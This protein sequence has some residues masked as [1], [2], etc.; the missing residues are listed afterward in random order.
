MQHIAHSDWMF[1]H[2]HHVN[3]SADPTISAESSQATQPQT[4]TDSVSPALKTYW[5]HAGD[6]TNGSSSSTQGSTSSDPSSSSGTR[7]APALTVANTALTVD[8]GG[9]TSLPI[10][11]SPANGHT[12]VTIAGLTN[13]ETVTDSL[14]GKTFTPD[15]NGSVTLSA[16]EVNSGLSLASGYTGTD[17]PVNTLTVTATETFAHHSLTSTSQSITVTDP[18]ATTGTSS[19]SASTSSTGATGTTSGGSDTLTLQVSGDQYNG[20]P[21]IEVFVDGQQV[22]NSTYTITAD[23]SSGQ[24]QTITITGNF[25]PSMAHQVQVQFVNDSWDGTSWWSNGSGPD[26]HDRNVYVESISLNGQ[27]LNGSQGTDAATNGVAPAANPNEAVM[28]ING[29]LTFNVPDP[30]ATTGTSGSTGT[31]TSGTSTST[32]GNGR[33]W[34]F[35]TNEGTNTAGWT[36]VNSGWSSQPIDGLSTVTDV[37]DGS[38]AGAALKWSPTP[39][40]QLLNVEYGTPGSGGW[41]GYIDM[42]QAAAGAYNATWL[43]WLQADA[44]AAKAE[45]SPVTVARIWQEINGDWFPWSVNETGYTSVDG[46]PNGSPWPAATIIKA[47]DNMAEQVRIAFPDAKIE[48]NLNLGGPWSNPSSPGNGSGFDLYPGDQYVD[49]IGVDTYENSTNWSTA[50]SGPGVNLNEAVAFATA[51]NKLVGISE[52]AAANGDGSYLTSMTNFMD[53]LGTRAAY[54][55][56]YDQGSAGAG[57][58]NVI[59]TTS[60]SSPSNPDAEP[61]DTLRAAL[62]ASSFGQEPYVGT[63]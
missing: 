55:S 61:A 39:K 16:A 34:A 40:A 5:H 45:N 30:S 15:A 53:S 56:Y 10:T 17:H 9:A 11:V 21:Q 44:A 58:V 36:S 57:N 27:T 41:P 60:Q 7:V 29:T 37:G 19:A 35:F 59:Y 31:S 33:D 1:E 12:S 20:D 48:W 3:T 24:T 50:V 51:H 49:V 38:W 2:S 52:T 4:Q 54:I 22:G 23:H 6:T 26:G 8:A 62:N 63:L 32:S 43:S 46:T 13:Y 28:D 25:D 42:G 47:W 18:P 14:D